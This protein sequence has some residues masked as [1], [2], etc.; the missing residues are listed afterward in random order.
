MVLTHLNMDSNQMKITIV[1]N[2]GYGMNQT[3]YLVTVIVPLSRKKNKKAIYNNVHKQD[4]DAN[5]EILFCEGGS[6]ASEA[7]NE[8]IRVAQGKYI[9]FLDDDDSWHPSKL[10]KQVE[11]LEQQPLVG[12]VT[13]WCEDYRF[14]STY[15]DT[16]P[17]YTYLHQLLR[18]FRYSSTS[19]YLVRK[20]TLDAVGYFDESFPSAQEYELAIRIAQHQQL[21]CVQEVLTYIGESENQITK[22]MKKKRDGLLKLLH[23]HKHLYMEYGLFDWIQF[24]GKFTCLFALT[25]IPSLTYKFVP[26]L[27]RFFNESDNFCRK[28]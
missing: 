10:R 9:A 8:G 24:V 17:V 4:I 21:Y 1:Q 19:S 15:L 23:K 27:K 16:Y 7:R 12:L 25:C 28:I 18:L 26:T 20:S 13:T 3:K 5:I 6:S 22:N 2:A 11:I 14:S